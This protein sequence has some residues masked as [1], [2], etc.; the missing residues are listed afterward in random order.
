MSRI[1]FI[2]LIFI[3][4][5]SNSRNY[6]AVLNISGGS[7]TLKTLDKS[8]RVQY[9]IGQQGPIGK[10][11]TMMVNVRQGFIQPPKFIETNSILDKLLKVKISPNPFTEVLDVVF[12]EEVKNKIKVKIYDLMGKLVF[13]DE[14]PTKAQ[15][16][17]YLNS[18]PE[19][20]FILR[21]ESKEKYFQT[22]IIKRK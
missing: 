11:N 9:S 22:K 21:L 2:I 6:R 1:F 20:Q 8:Y 4:F 16:K 18:I 15:H 10:I 13:E 17:I 12:S 14:L 7:K 5:H 3:S 19:S